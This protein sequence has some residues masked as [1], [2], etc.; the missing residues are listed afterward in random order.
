[1][2]ANCKEFVSD[3]LFKV[4]SFWLGQLFCGVSWLVVSWKIMTKNSGTRASD[5]FVSKF[6]CLDF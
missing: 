5:I 4:W 6:V 3:G 1:M 2:P